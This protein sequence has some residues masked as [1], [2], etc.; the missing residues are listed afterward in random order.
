MSRILIVLAWISIMGIPKSYAQFDEDQ[1]G[2]WYMYFFS[3]KM[4]DG[5]WGVQGDAQFRNWDL[6]GDL[7]QLLLR[8]GITYSPENANIKFTLGYGNITTGAFGDDNS[9]VSESRIYQEALFPTVFADRFFLTHRFRYEQ[10]WVEGQDM[11]TRYRYN[12]FMNIPL[13]QPNLKQGAIY[14]A[15]YNELFIN[16]ERSIGLGN[17][18]EIFDRNRFYTAVGYSI[19]DNLRTQLGVMKQT[20]NNW[21]KNQLQWSLHHSF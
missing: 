13:N 3:G 17:T 21:S 9:T 18:V 1:L 7:E 4:G 14:L 19:K 16:G 15:L 2:A 12:L 6:G 11:R 20:T 8:G 5:S 10:R